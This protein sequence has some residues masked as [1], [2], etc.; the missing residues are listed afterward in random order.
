MKIEIQIL[1]HLQKLRLAL[2]ERLSNILQEGDILNE[3]IESNKLPDDV[4]VALCGKCFY[5]DEIQKYQETNFYPYCEC[6]DGVNI[7]LVKCKKGE[8]DNAGEKITTQCVY[9]PSHLGD[10]EV[11]PSGYRFVTKPIYAII[12]FKSPSIIKNLDESKRNKLLKEFFGNIS[13]TY[14]KELERIRNLYGGFLS[15]ISNTLNLNTLFR[16]CRVIEMEDYIGHFE[17][18]RLELLVESVKISLEE[19]RVKTEKF[20]EEMKTRGKKFKKQQEEYEKFKK[21]KGRNE[22]L[23]PGCNKNILKESYQILG[24]KDLT[25]EP[26]EEKIK[27]NYKKLVLKF[28]PDKNDGIDTSELFIKINTSYINICKCRGINS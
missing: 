16:H 5:T 15:Y 4:K 7:H 23:E 1:K 19:G 9:W 6:H 3:Q 18:K 13:N 10:I 24:F 27:H 22:N 12:M 11:C 28:H 2:K 25:E 26:T 17:T 20:V 8:P 14:T 21:E